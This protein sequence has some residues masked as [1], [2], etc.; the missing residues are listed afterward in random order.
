[1]CPDFIPLFMTESYHHMQIH[2]ILFI[3]SLADGHCGFYLLAIVN[4]AVVNIRV[5]VVDSFLL[6]PSKQISMETILTILTMIQY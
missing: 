5:Q 6:L 2:H 1:M 3:H 4:S